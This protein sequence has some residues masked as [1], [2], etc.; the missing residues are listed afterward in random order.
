MRSDLRMR[1]VSPP[2]PGSG[3]TGRRVAGPGRGSQTGPMSEPPLWLFGDRLGPHVHATEELAGREIVLVESSGAL[4]RKPFHR[5]KL[6]L[7]LSGMRHRCGPCT[8]SSRPTA[9]GRA[10]RQRGGLHPAGAGLARVRLAAV[11]A[12]RARYTRRD[13]MGART[14]LPG[15]WTSLD[16][17]V[18]T[19]RCLSAALEQESARE[20]F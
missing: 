5:Q 1:G 11:P 2:R 19:A 18:V 9:R 13:A 6:H 12:F 3:P 8:P 16:A 15:W 17:D 14:P 4:G 10:A 7:M 20:E